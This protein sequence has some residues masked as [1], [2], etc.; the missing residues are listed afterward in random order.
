MSN[1]STLFTSHYNKTKNEF[2]KIIREKFEDNWKLNFHASMAIDETKNEIELIR[3]KF[4]I[5]EDYFSELRFYVDYNELLL[6]LKLLDKIIPKFLKLKVSSISVNDLIIELAKREAFKT[7]DT[8]IVRHHNLLVKLYLLK[9]FDGYQ[10]MEVFDLKDYN[11]NIRDTDIYI[12]LDGLLNNKEKFSS[13]NKPKINNKTNDDHGYKILPHYN[14]ES[15]DDIINCNHFEFNEMIKYKFA[16]KSFYN[17]L[18]HEFINKDK[19]SY[20]DFLKV[21]FINPEYHRSTITFNCTTQKASLLIDALIFN[22]TD[23]LSLS[24][25]GRNC[26][27]KSS[28]G[29]CLSQS[30]ISHSKNKFTKDYEA[31]ESSVRSARKYLKEIPLG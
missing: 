14:L 26:L 4:K 7:F 3:P 11:K 16:S 5:D 24:L 21:F 17:Y 2:V 30:S 15:I 13:K 19:T 6:N 8:L 23:K 29:N 20:L 22:Y 9:R 27:F 25:I 12:E 28:K 10:H 18:T 1:Y 31:N